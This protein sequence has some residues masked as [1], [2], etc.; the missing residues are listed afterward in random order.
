MIA[1]SL[2]SSKTTPSSA[3]ST[4]DSPAYARA[5]A[6][7]AVPS[8]ANR[9]GSGLLAIALSCGAMFVG[10]CAMPQIVDPGSD[11]S[12]STSDMMDGG[13]TGSKLSKWTAS[14]AAFSTLYSEGGPGVPA[15]RRWKRDPH[16][17][18][19]GTTE[20]VFMATSDSATEQWSVSYFAQQ[21][22][23]VT[24][25]SQWRAAIAGKA[26]TWYGTDITA[27]SAR[28]SAADKSVW[29]AANGDATRPDYVFQIG[30]A[31]FDG[32]NWTISQT[33]ALAA[34]AFSGATPTTARPDAYGATDPWVMTDGNNTTM[35][36]AGLDCAAT[37]CKF[38]ILRSVSTD[39]G[40]TFPPGSVVLTGRSGVPDET[41]GVAGPSVLY[42]NGQ[43]VM[44][45]TA[46]KTVPTKSRDGIRQALTSGAIG[47]AVSADGINWVPGTPTATSAITRIGTYRSEGASSPCLYEDGSAVRSYFGGLVIEQG[48]GF[49]YFNVATADWT[50]I[51][52]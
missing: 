5:V 3:V 29:F 16:Y 17:V 23:A 32:T 27:P 14:P 2:F 51:L 24:P 48:T 20:Y 33:P 50:E 31:T 38:Q 10:A 49:N 46:V 47:V 25:T 36:Y 13:T 12:V 52:P 4:I 42:R 9:T 7:P 19:D 1:R 28:F 45:Y 21:G 37:P 30:R 40:Q 34:P 22:S 18:K 44:A 39:G 43:W 6:G 11:G 35:Y 26:G 15:G 41:G 8:S